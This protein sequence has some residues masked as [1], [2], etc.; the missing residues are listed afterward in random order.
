M[1]ALPIGVFQVGECGAGRRQRLGQRLA[2]GIR[3][4]PGGVGRLDGVGDQGI[5]GEVLPH[6]AEEVLLGPP[7]KHAIGHGLD[8][9]FSPGRE[10]RG[11]VPA[12]TEPPDFTH[13]K[14]RPHGGPTLSPRR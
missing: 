1:R 14:P 7:L 3:H 10:D 6:V 2:G 11:L 5:E 9:Q 13:P 12:P 8:R 4:G